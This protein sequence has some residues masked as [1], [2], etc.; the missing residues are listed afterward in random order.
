MAD[1]IG[2]FG[3]KLCAA[4]GLAATVYAV[5]FRRWMLSWGSRVGSER[6]PMPGDD[7]EPDV[8]LT[9]RATT[10][11]AAPAAV[12]PWLIQMGQDRAGFY[13]HNWVERLLRSHPHYRCI[14]DQSGNASRSAT[15]YAP[16]RHRWQADGWP[17]V[18]VDPI[19][20]WSVSSR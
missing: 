2:R 16:I 9:T 17:V 19:D 8:A 11:K 18:A 4:G 1:M 7:I 15:W 14:H 13:T 12:W 5:L 20:R 10:I 3:W 6:G